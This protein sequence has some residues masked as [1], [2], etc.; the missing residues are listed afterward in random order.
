MGQPHNITGLKFGGWGEGA[1]EVQSKAQ[2]C[3]IFLKAF[4]K[5]FFECVPCFDIS[6]NFIWWI[7]R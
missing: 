2:E 3:H 1:M 6:K 5:K 7:S 4:P